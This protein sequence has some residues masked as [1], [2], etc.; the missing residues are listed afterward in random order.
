MNGDIEKVIAECVQPGEMIVDGEGKKNEE[1]RGI[2]GQQAAD[3]RDILYRVVYLDMGNV[4][5][6]EWI[7]ENAV[8]AEGYRCNDDQSLGEKERFFQFPVLLI[9]QKNIVTFNP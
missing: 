9:M 8:I 3:I 2:V 4:V 5:K 6:Q 7:V 1:S